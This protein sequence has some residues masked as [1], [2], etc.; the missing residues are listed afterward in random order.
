MIPR[1][2]RIVYWTLVACILLMSGVLVYSRMQSAASSPCAINP[3][4]PPPPTF[5]TKTPPSPSPTTPTAPSPST[6]SPSPSP[7]S[8][9]SGPASC[10]TASL[11]DLSLPS[12]THPI[13]P[14]PAVTDVFFLPLPLH[15]PA[16]PITDEDPAPADPVNALQLAVVNLT[17]TFADAHPSGIESEDLTIRAIITTLQANFPQISEVRF[18]VDGQ[19]RDTLAGHADLARTYNVSD[20]LRVVKIQ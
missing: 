18:L 15:N 3:P 20:T 10:S 8:P 6:R 4:S 7:P 19:P 11:T 14:G 1:Y 5:P 12:S 13:P 9:P 16:A 2:Q 17:K